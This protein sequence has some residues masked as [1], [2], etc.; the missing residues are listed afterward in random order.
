MIRINV[1]QPDTARNTAYSVPSDNPFVG[2]SR[3]LP[4]I[5]AYGLRNPWRCSIDRGDR[6]TREGRGRVFCGDVGQ[7]RFEE[8]DIIVSGGNYG[9]RAYEGNSCFD[10]DL[11]SVEASEVLSVCMCVCVNVIIL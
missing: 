9:W 1:D 11:C 6:V 7:S 10:D 2:N 8:V 3:Y 4:E 5:Y